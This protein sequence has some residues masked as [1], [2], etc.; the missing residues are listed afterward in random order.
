MGNEASLVSSKTSKGSDS[1]REKLA[2]IGHQVRNSLAQ[3]KEAVRL[4]TRLAEVYQIDRFLTGPD[5]KH[6]VREIN[7]NAVPSTLAGE[8]EVTIRT[9]N[10]HHFEPGNPHTSELERYICEIAGLDIL[11][12][13]RMQGQRYQKGQ[14][15]THHFD[16][17]HTGE[18]YWQH[19]ATHGGQRTWTAMLT[20]NQPREGGETDFPHL[21]LRIR[22]EPGRLLLWN[23]MLPDGRPNMKTLHAG[24]PVTRGIKH[25]VTLWFR[26]NPWRL[27][28]GYV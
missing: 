24:M 10:T 11:H 20:L 22:P 21:D 16:F 9:S 17:F 19:E 28:N 8:N 15:Y 26:E 3:V 1:D 12:A 5:C 25:I 14:Q 23:N 18:R 4:P 7:A 2:A 27:I 13:E 6:I